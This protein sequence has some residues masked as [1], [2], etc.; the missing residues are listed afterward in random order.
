MSMKIYGL[1]NMLHRKG[2]V[3]ILPL[4]RFLGRFAASEAACPG[5]DRAVWSHNNVDLYER[6]HPARSGTDVG[7]TV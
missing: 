2:P 5:N 7:A 3:A 1:K 6:F 4:L